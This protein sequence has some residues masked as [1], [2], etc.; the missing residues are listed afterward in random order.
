MYCSTHQMPLYP[1]TGAVNERGEHNT[2]VNA[3]LSPGDAARSPC[4]VGDRNPAP[5]RDFRPDLI[6]ISAGFDAHQR[7]PCQSQTFLEADSAGPRRSSWTSPTA[8]QMG[9][10]ILARGRLRPH[11]SREFRGRPTSVR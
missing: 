2:V 5:Q 1:G 8:A 3:P 4:R 9:A 11:R 6:V 10:S 7:T